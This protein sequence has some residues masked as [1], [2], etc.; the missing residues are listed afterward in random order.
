[1]QWQERCSPPASFREQ[2]FRTRSSAFPRTHRT[3]AAP[4]RSLASS[5]GSVE[6]RIEDRGE[7]RQKRRNGPDQ[8]FR[9]RPEP[10]HHSA[11]EDAQR[12]AEQKKCQKKWDQ[13]HAVCQERQARK[14]C[15]PKPAS[16]PDPT[17]LVAMA[18]STS[19]AIYSEIDKRRREEIQEIARPDIFEKSRGHALHHADEEIPQQHRAQ[20]RRHEIEA[21]AK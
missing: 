21:G 8:P 19:P 10:Q 11:G 16:L 7:W 6:T 12:D 2:L 14:A 1:M 5:S 15:S 17:A 3:A 20:Q 9:S 13:Q 4:A 18:E